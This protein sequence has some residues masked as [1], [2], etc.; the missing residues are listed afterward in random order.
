MR[1]ILILMTVLVPGTALAQSA[2]QPPAVCEKLALL[3]LP[4]T[5]IG[6][7]IGAR[8]YR[9]LSDRNFYDI[10]LGLLFVSGLV[11]VSTSIGL[12]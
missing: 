5:L 9:A 10:V 7:W 3:S 8:T 11:L 2:P 1:S 6:S 4:S 12:R